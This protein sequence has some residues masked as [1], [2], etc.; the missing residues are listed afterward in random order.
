MK[1]QTDSTGIFCKYP[2]ISIYLTC[3]WLFPFSGFA[4]NYNH[5]LS[6]FQTVELGEGTYNYYDN[7]G[8][9]GNYAN[10]VSSWI[11]FV[12]DEGHFMTWQ[13]ITYNIEDNSPSCGGSCCDLLT[14][15]YIPGCGDVGVSQSYCG[16]GQEFGPN[17][18]C[19]G[20]S[21]EFYFTSDGSVTPSGWHI[22]IEVFPNDPAHILCYPESDC[23]VNAVGGFLECSATP[24]PQEFS[25]WGF[26]PCPGVITSYPDCTSD[27]YPGIERIYGFNLDETSTVTVSCDCILAAFIVDG[28]GD[29]QCYEGLFNNGEYEFENIPPGFHYLIIEIECGGDLCFCDMV[30]N[31]SVPTTCPESCCP[32]FVY[33]YSKCADFDNYN[34][35]NIVPQGS[36][37]FELFEGLQSQQAVV[38]TLQKVSGTKS[39]RFTATSDINYVINRTIDAPTR[40]EWMTYIPNGKT[41][42]FGFYTTTPN[43]YPMHVDYANGIATVYIQSSP[44]NSQQVGSFSYSSNTWFKSVIIFLPNDNKIEYWQN[45]VLRY[46][47]T[48]YTSNQ[49]GKLNFYRL[50][51]GSSEFFID[52]IC[53][54][55]KQDFPV[56][57]SEDYIPVCVNG[58]E[59]P[60]DCYAQ[61]AGYSECE[62]TDGVCET[63]GCADCDVCFNFIPRYQAD[64]IVDFQSRY[65]FTDLPNLH[66]PVER[67]AVTTYL[68]SVPNATEQYVNSTSAASQNPS[69]Q[70]P[71]SGTYTVCQ[72][73]FENGILVF[74]CCRTVFIGTCST[75]PVAFF[76]AQEVLFGRFQLNANAGGNHIQWR[77]LD[78][79]AFFFQG[80]ENSSNPVVVLP[81]GT[82]TN[83]CLYVTN[84]CGTSMYCMEICV[85][86]PNCSGTLPPVWLTN[87]VVPVIEDNTVEIDL[88]NPPGGTA[89]YAWDLGDGETA[90]TQD[91]FHTYA[92]DGNYEVCVTMTIGCR[93]WCYCWN[94]PVNPCQ[95]IYT[96]NGGDLQVQFSGS[97]TN[98]Q[99]TIT[100]SVPKATGESWLVNGLPVSGNT[101]SLVYTFP[102][103]GNYTVCFPYLGIDGCIHYYCIDIG[104]GNP[105][106]C[107]SITWQ[108][109]AATGYRFSIPAGNTQISWTI[110]ETGQN[111]GN[112]NTSNWLLPI[113]PCTW[114]TISVKYFDGSRYRICCLRI[115]LCPPDE[116]AAS[117]AYGYLASTNQA[118]FALS[119]SG[120]SEITWFYDDAPSQVLG[121]AVNLAIPYPGTCLSRWISVRYKDSTGHWRICCRQIYFCNPIA[122]SAI[123]IN[124]VAGSGYSFTVDQSQQQ[125]SWIVE[126]T[127]TSLGSGLTSSFLPVGATCEYRTVS[128]RYWDPVVGWRLCCLRFYWCN[129]T[130]CEDNI[131]FSTLGNSLV[132]TA[133]DN[134]QNVSWYKDASFLGESNPLN[135]TLLAT[136]THTICIR[137]TDPCDNAWKWCCRTYTPG[138]SSSNLT[139]DFADAICGELDEVIDIP[140]RVKGFNNII[141]FQFSVH[142]DDTTKG[143]LISL[144]PQN[145]QGDFESSVTTTQTGGIYWENNSPVSLSD[146]TIIAMARVRIVSQ[147]A[148]Q[149]NIR[150]TDDPIPVYAEDGAGNELLPTL[151]NGSFCHESLI[152]ICGKV[153]R[154]DLL[155][156]ANVNMTLQG[157]QQ[158]Q[159]KTDVNGNYC[160]IDVPSGKSYQVFAS[161]DT[162]DKNGVNS[163]DLTAIK[164]HILNILKL[165]TPYKIAAADAKKSREV[166]TGDVSELR[167]LILGTFTTLPNCESWEFTDKNYVFPVPA[168]PFSMEW[169]TMLDLPNVMQDI[170]N[171]DM[172]GWKMGDVNQSNNPQS[173]LDDE[174]NEQRSVADIYL[175]AS[176]ESVQG[177]DTF[178]VDISARAFE[179]V[180]NG[181]FSLRFDPA[182]FVLHEVG[183]Y[184]SLMDLSSDNFNID[185]ANG[186]LGFVWDATDGVTLPDDAVLFSLK[187]TSKVSQVPLS[188]VYFSEDPV[189]YYFENFDGDELNVITSN[190]TVTVPT[191]EIHLNELLVIPN[192]N[193]G[194]FTITGLEGT[195]DQLEVIDA[196]GV[197][198]IEQRN[199]MN[200]SRINLYLPQAGL[201]M[202]RVRQTDNVYLA[203][204]V[205][206]K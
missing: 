11:T 24:I 160:F 166:N 50:L 86:D 198:V 177:L 135:T 85:S 182:T 72:Q 1:S 96:Y 3:L 49:I 47:V 131:T 158:F 35:G 23:Y 53:Y 150:M 28:C 48:N 192:P 76:T 136:A 174:W 146:N 5:P 199:V 143:K 73:V 54:K 142:I 155:P 122:C 51:S 40:L 128:L 22:S 26:G 115:Y 104:A 65:C 21:L 156:I 31:C 18:L 152:N 59:Y 141:N 164:R 133:P 179:N 74:E 94:I 77:L 41:G 13:V 20:E 10:N 88:P 64:N 117:I 134:L 175:F 124:Y 92:D 80:T 32:S 153:T 195:I 83:V 123:R 202:I 129:P 149:T 171:A 45:G 140:L 189:P 89:T 42:A 17:Y 67:S 101:S 100:A 25:C 176:S 34:T 108:F 71:G 9:N 197:T 66:S 56:W 147:T 111:I 87:A 46:T 204:V 188:E 75:P 205:V 196:R 63:A 168:N 200:A 33:D 132:L 178:W 159:T 36:P 173:D 125:M 52:D 120:A 105:F 61:E 144:V 97:E 112:S 172:I 43:I 121:T 183:Q 186:S 170:N 109:A 4:Q 27:D 14:A 194:R 145:I 16:T 95:S 98:L 201:Y 29:S 37:Q 139:F 103:A 107:S 161:K 79:D 15:T 154:G 62:W 203:R 8:P 68:W 163:G 191:N 12:P 193:T 185:L 148:G 6:G 44:N 181:Q 99:Y 165:N 60:N 167:R 30:F 55:E 127:G 19:G 180:N 187:F 39:L 206:T 113:S 70:F 184:H 162:N 82:C 138:G 110:D 90:T 81:G 69:I 169:P 137:Y 118:T 151:Q 114:R 58:V 106:A 93:T 57:C 38:S 190:G 126:E 2:V 116:C 157:C 130:A 84:A 91:V 119:A 78:P 102:T 7:G